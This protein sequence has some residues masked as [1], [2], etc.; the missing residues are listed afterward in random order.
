MAAQRQRA[1]RLPWRAADP[2]E[3]FD[4]D[5]VPDQE[6]LRRIAAGDVRAL[7]ATYD[8]HIDAVWRVA[9][10]FAPDEPGA[11]DAVM[12]AFLELWRRPAPTAGGLGLKARLLTSVRRAVR[13]DG[14]WPEVA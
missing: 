13:Q 1:I 9:I 10:A 14:P 6:L 3:S 5:H 8:R 2:R 11:T 4:G 7:E 12:T